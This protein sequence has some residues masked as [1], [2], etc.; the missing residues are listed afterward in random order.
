MLCSADTFRNK[1]HSSTQLQYKQLSQSVKMLND[2]EAHT[3]LRVWQHD[4]IGDIS[5]LLPV[6]LD[7]QIPFPLQMLHFVVIREQALDGIS[8]AR[9]HARWSFF[10]WCYERLQLG[11]RS[12]AAYHKCRLVDCNKHTKSTCSLDRLVGV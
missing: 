1:Q 10:F 9:N 11:L 6:L 8:A 2:N 12:I 4:D 7:L 3:T 5:F